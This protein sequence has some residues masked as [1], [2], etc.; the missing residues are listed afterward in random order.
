MKQN[1]KPI[2]FGISSTKLTDQE[3]DFLKKT[4]PFGFILFSRNI[5][6]TEQLMQLTNSL[7]NL[8]PDRV[9][10]PIFVDQEGGRVARIKPPIAQEEYSTAEHF[11]KIYD[12]DKSLALKE[13]YQNYTKLM[14]ELKKLGIDSP[15]APVGD[16]R[17][18]EASDVIGDRSFGENPGKVIDLCKSVIKAIKDSN[19]IAIIKHIPGHGRALQDSHY[20][21]PHVDASLSELK[22]SDFKVFEELAKL[23]DVWGMTAHI[24]FNAIDKENPVTLSKKA[25]KYIRDEIGFKG[26][27]LT[28]DIGMLALHGEVGVKKSVLK[29]IKILVNQDKEWQS[30]YGAKL[31]DLFDID[32]KI[33]DNEKISVLCDKKEEELKEDFLKSLTLVSK[34]ALAAGCDF[35]LH[36]S[37]DIEE[38]IA[39]NEAVV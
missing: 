6:S 21:L 23:D 18:K 39:V 17:V 30:Q 37:G 20:D 2:I 35:L 28:D 15:C 38:M 25:I 7:K 13:V 34:Q 19:G 31:Q 4:T 10:T 22:E 11:A 9:E 1:Y 33:L 32:A 29:K 27:L 24:V 14:S 5:E 26:T 16:L 8:Y 3:Y 12:S 36:C